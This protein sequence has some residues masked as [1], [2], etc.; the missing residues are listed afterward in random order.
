MSK[1]IS[2]V[3]STAEEVLKCYNFFSSVFEQK[4][5]HISSDK[6]A[7]NNVKYIDNNNDYLIKSDEDTG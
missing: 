5:S 1:N 6:S 3:L 7:K 2:Y 4:D